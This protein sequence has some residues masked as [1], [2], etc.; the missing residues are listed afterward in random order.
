MH[1]SEAPVHVEHRVT[2]LAAEAA[3]ERL[4]AGGR[5]MHVTEHLVHETVDHAHEPNRVRA[6]VGRRLI[7]LGSAIAGC[8]PAADARHPA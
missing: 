6:A 5:R 3:A 4:A 2:S 1:P 8:S 7:D